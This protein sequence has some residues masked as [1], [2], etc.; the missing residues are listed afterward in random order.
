MNLIQP[1]YLDPPHPSSANYMVTW[2]EDPPDPRPTRRWVGGIHQIHRREAQPVPGEFQNCLG[3]RLT[4]RTAGYTYHP[5]Q[6]YDPFNPWARRRTTPTT[7]AAPATTSTVTLSDRALSTIPPTTSRTRV[8]TER[9]GYLEARSYTEA[10]RTETTRVSNQQFTRFDYTATTRPLQKDPGPYVPTPSLPST[11]RRRTYFPVWRGGG[12][13]SS[14][15]PASSHHRV[16]QPQP[17]RESLSGSEETT[18]RIWSS[19]SMTSEATTWRSRLSDTLGPK[20]TKGT[21]S[22]TKRPSGTLRP[23]RPSGTSRPTEGSTWRT[24]VMRRRGKVPPTFSSSFYRDRDL[25]LLGEEEDSSY[26]VAEGRDR[27][28]SSLTP[29]SETHLPQA[30]LHRVLGHL[31]HLFT[32]ALS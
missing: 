19:G 32:G 20:E 16:T 4:K 22:P 13:G 14:E 29:V 27:T 26:R 31:R 2:K 30:D 3:H 10:R 28:Y 6:V 9:R 11:Q 24:M 21:F 17:E 7:T 12:R 8:I 25:R 5:D 23:Q 15:R 18:Q 1:H